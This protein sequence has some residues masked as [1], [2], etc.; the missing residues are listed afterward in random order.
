MNTERISAD[1]L[2]IGASVAGLSAAISAKEKDPDV[3]ILVVEKYF[4]GYA[5]KANRGAGIAFMLGNNTP[6]EFIDFQIKNIGLY[7]NKQDTLQK[8]VS[9]SNQNIERLDSWTKRVCRDE[10]GKLITLKWGSKIVGKKEN[11]KPLFQDSEFPW[12]LVAIELDY[13]L[14]MKK[15]ARKLGVK[16]IDRVGI[17]DFLKDGGKVCGAIG[18]HIEEEKQYAFTAKAVIAAHGNQ[19]YRIMPMW[20]PGRGE[21]IS[22]A[23]RAGAEFANCEY[24]SFY[25]WISLESFESS[26]GVE[27]ALYNDKGENVG[28]QHRTGINSDIDSKTLAEWYLQM[29]AGNGPMHYHMH[30]NTLMQ[31]LT[32]VLAS[33]NVFNRPYAD[34]FWG[35]L[36]FNAFSSHTHDQIVP[37]LISEFS[38]LKVDENMATTLPGLFAAG[39]ICYAGSRLV[40]SVACS[41]GR[42]R[43]GGIAYALFSGIEAGESAIDYVASAHLCEC[44]EKQLEESRN[45]MFACKNRIGGIHPKEIVRQI[46]EVVN[47]IGNSLYMHEQRLNY[48]LAE[49]ARIGDMLDTVSASDMHSIFE[50]NEA[51]SMVLCAEMFYKSAL[52]RKESRSWFLREDYPDR[53][54]KNYLKWFIVKDDS[55][56]VSISEERV[57]IE[58][59]SLRP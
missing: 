20:S 36:F 16:F 46:Q 7:L 17:V 28:K 22:A 23:Y 4:S 5:G 37:G 38:P 51:K 8:Y 45:A 54:D 55:G 57:P 43:G 19:N 11:G 30:E 59:Y 41:P 14:E 9:K 50:Y 34:K 56:K 47:P 15:T 25:N 32:S 49:V 1:I 42:I 40:G 31:S 21:G 18:Y 44:D 29:R 48:A 53:D 33:D 52:Q 12:T 6:E 13:I 2:V 3:N 10:N 58:T 39:D 35:T 24:G 27:E 26:M